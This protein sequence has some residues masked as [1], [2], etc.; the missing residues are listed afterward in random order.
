MQSCFLCVLAAFFT[1]DALFVQPKAAAV[2]VKTSSL[3]TLELGPFENTVE[4]CKAC[5]ASHTKASVVPNCI[6]TA[7]NGDDG[8]TMY[9]TASPAGVGWSKRQDGS[10]MCMQHNLAKM[11]QTT[12][13]AHE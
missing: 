5:F 1:A 6:C 4:A 9:C 10:C 8:A 12:C 11:G 13:E 3:T 2:Q 7:F